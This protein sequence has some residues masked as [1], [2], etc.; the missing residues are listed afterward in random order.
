[1]PDVLFVCSGNTCRSPMAMCL[2]NDFSARAGLA[3]RAESAG[4][5]ALDG[6][7]ASDGAF[8]VMKERGLDLSRHTAQSLTPALI[9]ASRLIVTM[10]AAHSAGVLDRYPGARVT[11]FDPAIRDPY[12]SSL[13]AYRATA[14]ELSARMPWVL[15]HLKTV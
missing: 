8:S 13:A 11:A 6:M 1:M 5:Y 4:L 12:G 2:F 3:Y 14:D 9:R 15:S 7:P 10:S